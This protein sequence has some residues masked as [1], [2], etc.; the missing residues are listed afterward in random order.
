[1]CARTVNFGFV[2]I[3]AILHCNFLVPFTFPVAQLHLR[4]GRKTGE[5]RQQRLEI[6]RGKQGDTTT[7]RSCCAV[8]GLC[9]PSFLPSCKQL[10]CSY[11]H[12]TAFT[13]YRGSLPLRADTFL[14]KGTEGASATKLPEAVLY[15]A[16]DF[17]AYEC[18]KKSKNLS[19]TLHVIHPKTLTY[20]NLLSHALLI[21]KN[22]L[23]IVEKTI[24]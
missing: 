21:E 4:G 20:R 16:D 17:V 10:G 22:C 13:C 15:K 23:I 24:F 7:W 2:G 11:K 14:G 18:K 3:S 6:R 8:H 1:M 19:G 12:S 9:V 5:G